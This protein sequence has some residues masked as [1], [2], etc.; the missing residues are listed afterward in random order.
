MRL[1]PTIKGS[2]HLS[3]MAAILHLSDH[4]CSLFQPG[5]ILPYYMPKQFLY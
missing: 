5:Y 3:P 4:I 1:G 2:G